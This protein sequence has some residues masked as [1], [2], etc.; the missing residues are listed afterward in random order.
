M[1][2][3]SVHDTLYLNCETHGP[4]VRDLS[5]RKGPIW[6]YIVKTRLLQICE[7]KNKCIVIKNLDALY[8]NCEFMFRDS[9]SKVCPIWPFRENAFKA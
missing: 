7:K 9:D 4:W 2:S 5:H 6:P 8:L 3:Y 1:H